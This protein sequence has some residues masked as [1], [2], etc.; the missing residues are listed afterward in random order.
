M[1]PKVVF[2]TLSIL[3]TVWRPGSLI[4]ACSLLLVASAQNAASPFPR[5][6]SS[7]Q[8]RQSLG[9]HGV[10]PQLG[11][12]VPP[13]SSVRP[14][15]QKRS[16]A[17]KAQ[18]S[19][20]QTQ[21]PLFLE[22]RQYPTGIGPNSIA[23]GDF[24][25]DGTPD[26]VVANYEGNSLSVLLGNG[27]GTFRTHVD[28]A[29][30]GSRATSV[31]VADFNGDNKSDVAVIDPGSNL[32]SVLLGN[33]DGTFQTHMNYPTGTDPSSIAVADFNGDGKPDLA[34]THYINAVSVLLG[35]GDGSFQMYVDYPTANSATSVTVVDFNGDS[36]L[37]LLVA[38][39]YSYNEGWDYKT[40][41]S[42]GVLLG[43][44]DGTFQSHMEYPTGVYPTSVAV[45]DFNGDGKLDVATANYSA[46]SVSV[47]LGNGDG[48]FQTNV[49]YPTAYGPNFVAIGDFNLDGE[50][51]L[52]TTNSYRNVISVLLGNGDGTFRWRSSIQPETCPA[53]QRLATSTTTASRTCRSQIMEIIR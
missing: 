10:K 17:R 47:L 20:E 11:H 1:N 28:Y 13:T 33:G 36:K 43:N 35:N 2:R 52:I 9:P 7:D 22:D 25:G 42:V 31:A 29:T 26:L 38:E 8:V 53:R 48:T 39:F 32:V 46:T 23:L 18:L 27:D 5:Q 21:M 51:D 16:L 41:N 30:G 50:P 49:D 3:V 40:I 12:A 6:S 4:L 14:N 34:I 45:A 37:D 15:L 24:N 19:S 44:G